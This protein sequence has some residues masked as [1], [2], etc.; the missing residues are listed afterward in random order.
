MAA[1]VLCFPTDR[2]CMAETETFRAL[3]ERGL[4]CHRSPLKT[5][6]DFPCLYKPFVGERGNFQD[7]L[8][9]LQPCRAP[10]RHVRQKPAVCHMCR[11]VRERDA[12]QDLRQCFASE[13]RFRLAAHGPRRAREVARARAGQG[14]CLRTG[15]DG[16][17]T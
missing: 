11:P 8:Q 13:L 17:S 15:I 1:E 6:V 9:L 12:Q 5:Y 7:R 10:R 3:H 16:R 2:L 4:V 14:T